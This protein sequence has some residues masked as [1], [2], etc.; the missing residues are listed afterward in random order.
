MTNQKIVAIRAKDAATGE[1]LTGTYPLLSADDKTVVVRHPT[2]GNIRLPKACAT[3]VPASAG[4][5]LTYEE[6]VAQIRESFAVLD[7]LVE[8]IIKGE[9]RSLIVSGAPGVGKTHTTEGRLRQA[10]NEGRISRYTK[11]TGTAS[12]IGLYTLLHQHR[13]DGDVLLLDDADG[14]LENLDAL[15]MLKACLDTGERRIVSYVKEAQTLKDQGI[16]QRF[17]FKGR[18]IFISNVD[19]DGIIEGGG[20]LAPHLRALTDRSM[21]LDTGLHS[22]QALVARIEQVSRD[23]DMLRKLGLS[24]VQIEETVQWIKD[25]APN[26]RSLSLRT[27]QNL[28]VQVK[29]GGE[30]KAKAKKLFLKA[31]RK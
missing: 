8:D 6:L 18:V 24:D 15:N 9:I 27:A 23:T 11:I 26:L 10:K 22:Q 21:Y 25:N 29:K 4:A 2:R 12:P 14:I 28:G 31:R 3:E 16:P 13:F 20:K 30:W 17:E 19:F 1:S 7:G 5:T